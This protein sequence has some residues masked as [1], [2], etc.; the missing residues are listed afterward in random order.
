MRLLLLACLLALAGCASHRSEGTVVANYQG[1][2]VVT[3]WKIEVIR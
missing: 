1:V 2:T 3:A